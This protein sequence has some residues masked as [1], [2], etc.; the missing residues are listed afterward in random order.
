M[1]K[2]LIIIA[3]GISSVALTSCEGLFGDFLDK[4]PSFELREDQVF[5]DWA[6]A[7]R[8]HYIHITPDTL[9]PQTAH[10]ERHFRGSET[11]KIS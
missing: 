9:M 2:I 8:F 4:D 10:I 6:S 11:F 5:S 7:S 1:N 3:F